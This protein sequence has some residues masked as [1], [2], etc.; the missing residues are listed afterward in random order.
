MEGYKLFVDKMNKLSVEERNKIIKRIF[1]FKKVILYSLDEEDGDV[2]FRI[3]NGI[4][5][6][7]IKFIFEI[8]DKNGFLEIR[9]TSISLYCDIFIKK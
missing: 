8:K 1:G 3:Y 5:Y 2:V 4:R 6:Y 7:R 9:D